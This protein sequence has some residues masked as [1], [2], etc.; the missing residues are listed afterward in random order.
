MLHFSFLFSIRLAPHII[1]L[2]GGGRS[3]HGNIASGPGAPGSE[4]GCRAQSRGGRGMVSGWGDKTSA[5]AWLLGVRCAATR[6]SSIPA[7]DVCP[8]MER[9]HQDAA[10]CAVAITSLSVKTEGLEGPGGLQ[11]MFSAA[12][13]PSSFHKL[14]FS[15]ADRQL[16]ARVGYV[17]LQGASRAD[18]FTSFLKK[19]VSQN[20]ISYSSSSLASK[21]L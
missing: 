9:L 19:N 21:H 7:P 13:Q 14:S 20:N 5:P 15:H 1:L 8:R 4:T 2:T 11:F 6:L 17:Q 10:G 18:P 12:F 3:V 16:A